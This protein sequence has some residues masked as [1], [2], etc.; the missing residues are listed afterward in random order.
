MPLFFKLS[1]NKIKL[2][3]ELDISSVQFYAYFVT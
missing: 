2:Q 1:F 3:M